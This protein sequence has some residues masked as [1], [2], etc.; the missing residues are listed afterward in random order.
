MFVER[1]REN[2]RVR[3]RAREWERERERVREREREREREQQII[4]KIKIIDTFLFV[5]R[6]N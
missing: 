2:G 1:M 3:K 6:A 4:N 5:Q